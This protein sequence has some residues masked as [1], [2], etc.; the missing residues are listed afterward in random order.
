MSLGQLL[1]VGLALLVA[2]PV[3][4]QSVAYRIESDETL[5]YEEAS[6]WQTTVDGG[7]QVPITLLRDATISITSAD[8]GRWRA[9]YESFDVRS[10]RVGGVVAPDREFLMGRP[11]VLTVSEAGDVTLEEAPTILPVFSDFYDPTLQFVD[12]LVP[13]PDASLSEGATWADTVGTTNAPRR[14][15]AVRATRSFEVVGDTILDGESALVIEVRSE[16]EYR[17]TLPVPGWTGRPTTSAKGSENGY[18]IYSPSSRTLLSRT[19]SGELSGTLTTGSGSVP[20]RIRYESDLV[21]SRQL[22]SN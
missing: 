6:R 16:I 11:F 9:E 13:I 7:N 12:F 5:R 3:H 17:S 22:R 18:A 14:G 4:A 20:I 15:S 1:R 8:S 2:L 19:R 21:R 10:I